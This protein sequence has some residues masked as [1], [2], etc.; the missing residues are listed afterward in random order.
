MNFDAGSSPK[1]LV[2]RAQET[3]DRTRGT[4]MLSLIERSIETIDRQLVLVAPPDARIPSEL[5]QLVVDSEVSSASIREMQKLRGSIYVMEG[6]IKADQLTRDG[7]HQTAEDDK[8]WHLLMLNPDRR[9][10][11][12]ALY[13]EHD[14]SVTMDDLRVRHCPLLDQ[15]QWRETLTGAVESE[16]ERARRDGLRYAELGGWAIEKERRGTPEGLV[17]A[18]ATYALSR[19]LGG[20]LGITTANVAHSCSSILRRFGGSFLEFGGK[21]VPA[22]FDPR[23]DTDIELLRFDSRAPG[24]R[25]ARLIDLVQRKL[26][27]VPVL[28]PSR[29]AYLAAP[30][31]AA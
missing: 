18:L 31:A 2:R 17:F 27:Q 15:E 21:T 19:M 5:R 7:R 28:A 8:S 12:C 22:Y 14:N 10:R 23:Y 29:N 16:I 30:P 25:Y 4:A 9:V 26:E 1:E 24:A 11:S 3:K 6:N 13:L 20:A